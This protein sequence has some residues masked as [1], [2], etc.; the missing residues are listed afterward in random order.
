MQELNIHP[1]Y[2]RIFFDAPAD[3]DL[4][5]AKLFYDG[6][7]IPVAVEPEGILTAGE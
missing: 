4:Q 7:Q 5:S 3:Y 1:G 6:K 2:I